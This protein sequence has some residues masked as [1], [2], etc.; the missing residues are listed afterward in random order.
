MFLKVFVFS[1]SVLQK[2]KV[3]FDYVSKKKQK[4]KQLRFNYVTKKR[5]KKKKQVAVKLRDQKKIFVICKLCICYACDQHFAS[6][7]ISLY[8]YDYQFLASW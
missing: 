5:E 7:F 8:V 6:V 1:V 4:P 2:K 3:G